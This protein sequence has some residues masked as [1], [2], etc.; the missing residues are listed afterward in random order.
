LS[1]PVKA[2]GTWAIEHQPEIARARMQFDARN[3]K[4]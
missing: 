3:E 4:G 1:K 2:L